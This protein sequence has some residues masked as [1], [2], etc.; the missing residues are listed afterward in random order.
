MLSVVVCTC[1]PSIWKV[2]G[3]R[4]KSL[5]PACAIEERKTSVYKKEATQRKKTT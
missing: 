3:R 4:I 1:N 2:E 5:Y